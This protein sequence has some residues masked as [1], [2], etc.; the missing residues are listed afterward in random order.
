MDMLS[1][2]QS[3]IHG[4]LGDWR[5]PPDLY[6]PLPL[7]ENSMNLSSAFLNPYIWSPKVVVSH[8]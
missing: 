5:L 7:V 4:T 1:C 2:Q 6:F 8:I 3:V